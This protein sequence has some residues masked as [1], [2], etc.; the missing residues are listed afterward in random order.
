MRLT[1]CQM[2]EYLFLDHEVQTQFSRS[3]VQKFPAD[4]FQLTFGFPSL[5]EIGPPFIEKIRNTVHQ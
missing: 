3:Q 2:Q 1:F 4:L 5:I